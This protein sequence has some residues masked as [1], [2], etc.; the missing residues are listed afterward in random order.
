MNQFFVSFPLDPY[1]YV[2]ALVCA[3]DPAEAAVVAHDQ[4]AA[5]SPK[6]AR[7]LPDKPSLV[8]QVS[9]A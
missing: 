4:I 8:K 5:L 1:S 6:L 2:N 7:A 3:P 9:P